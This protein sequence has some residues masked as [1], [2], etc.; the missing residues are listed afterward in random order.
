MRRKLDRL[1]D[2]HSVRLVHP[3]PRIKWITK[4]DERGREISRRRSPKSGIAA[5]VCAELVSF[6]SLLDHPNF[7]LEVLLTEEE[8]VW[9]PDARGWRRG[10]FVVEE[11]RLVGVLDEVEFTSPDDLCDLLPPGLPDPFT[12][13]DLA[14]ALRRTRHA[15]QEVAYCLRESG[16]IDVAGRDRRGYLYRRP[17][18]S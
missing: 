9:R 6:P 5:D 8:E 1:V 17:S 18:D 4:T 12:T 13:K 11:R 3:V 7:T 10:G 15:A 2:G 14:G 16:A